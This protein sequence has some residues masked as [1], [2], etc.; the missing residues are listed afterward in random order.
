MAKRGRKNAYD[1]IIKPQFDFIEK[2]LANGATEEQVAEA[3]GVSMST[4]CKHKSENVEFSEFIKK[5][6]RNLVGLLRSAIV[7]KALGYDYIEEKQ[8]KTM[9]K[10]GGEHIKVEKFKKHMSPDVAALNLCLK[11][12]DKENWS[13]DPQSDELKREELRLKFEKFERENWE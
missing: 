7:K 11:N 9:S 3:L 8:Y 1:E 4:W 13:N 10:D 12:Y 2:Q 6:R 5:S